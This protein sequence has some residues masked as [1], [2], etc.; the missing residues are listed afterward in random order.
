MLNLDA[1]AGKHVI[2][3]V[4]LD[5]VR[6]ALEAS[7]GRRFKLVANLPYHV[8]TP[9]ITNLLVQPELCP[10]LMVVTIQR[11]MADRLCASPGDPAYGAVSVVVQAQ[12]DVSSLSGCCRPRCSGRGRRSSR[13]CSRSGRTPPSERPLVMS[14]GFRRSFGACSC[15]VASTCGTFWRRCGQGSG[16]R[17]KS[18]AGCDRKGI[19]V[20]FA[21]KHSP[22]RSSCR[23]RMPFASDLVSFREAFLAR[24]RR[25]RMKPTRTID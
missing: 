24:R 21:Q 6:S 13:R 17:P 25:W 9:L 8:A 19:A 7:E 11:E 5:S 18:M 2:D 20:R 12:A 1:L 15:T 23:W 3:P 14:L 16:P 10:V 4:V 22:S